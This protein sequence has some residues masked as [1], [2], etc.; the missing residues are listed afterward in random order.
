M[1]SVFKDVEVKIFLAIFHH[2]KHDRYCVR[3]KA[4]KMSKESSFHTGHCLA[5]SRSNQRFLDASLCRGKFAA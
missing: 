1:N 4:K 5:M 2:N 3:E